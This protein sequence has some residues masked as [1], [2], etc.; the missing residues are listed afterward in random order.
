MTD[1][2]RF[3]SIDWQRVP[4][5]GDRAIVLCDKDRP[6]GLAF[7]IGST[8]NIDGELYDVRRAEHRDLAGPL[9]KGEHI[10]LWVSPHFEAQMPNTG[11]TEN[12]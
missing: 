8:V 12:A 10:V 2:P 5:R 3:S 1:R 9:V 6:D 7:V 4:L 11:R